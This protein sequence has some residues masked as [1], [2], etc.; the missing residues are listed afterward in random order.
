MI[1]AKVNALESK[2]IKWMVGTVLAST[3]LAF[4]IAKFVH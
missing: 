1:D 3:G 4:S 2:I